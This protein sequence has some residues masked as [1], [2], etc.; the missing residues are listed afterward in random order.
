MLADEYD[1]AQEP[2]KIAGP[3]YGKLGR[4][5]GE[6]LPT[7]ADIGLSR[8]DVHDAR[9]IRDAEVA[10]SG[11]VRRTLDEK[12]ASG[13]EPTNAA[14]RKAV[15]ESPTWR[16]DRFSGAHGVKVG[17]KSCTCARFASLSEQPVQE[18][19]NQEEA[20]QTGDP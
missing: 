14:L 5:D 18:H 6:R 15:N 1:A 12:L 10:D 9:L 3:K 16:L 19:A 7:A 17:A 2:G 11:V 4:S 8:K 13:E 20:H